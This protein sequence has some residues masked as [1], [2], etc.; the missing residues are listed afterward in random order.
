MTEQSDIAPTT[1]EAEAFAYYLGS[2]LNRHVP[3]VARN[4]DVY[5]LLGMVTVAFSWFMRVKP[6]LETKL[7]KPTSAKPLPEKAREVGSKSPAE[8][9]LEHTEGWREQAEQLWAVG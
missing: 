7:K 9:A 1:E 2:L 4:H 3:A 8:Q 6:R 5:D